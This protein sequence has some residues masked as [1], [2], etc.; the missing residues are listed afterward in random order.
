M[1]GYGVSDI[2]T[3]QPVTEHTIFFTGSTSKAFT[4]AAISL[5][6]DDSINFPDIHW[7][8]LVHTILPTDFV[9]ND[10]WAT[11]QMTIVDILSHRSG[12]PRHDWVWLANIT[13]QEAVQSMQHLPFT[14]SPRTEWQYC[15]LMYSAASHLIETVTNQSLQSFLRDNIWLP[16]DMTETYLSLS[17]SQDAHRDISQG[18]FVNLDGEI[19]PTDRVST[20]IL[21]GAGNIL[22]SV[23]DYSKWVSTMLNRGPPF[24]SAGYE[25]LF[26]AHSIESLNPTEPFQSPTL[27]GLGWTIQ[28]YKG[29]M[30]LSHGGAQVGYGASVILLPQRNFGLV[31][32][33]NNMNGIS[34]AAD[35]LAYHLID[36]ELEVPLERRYDWVARYANRCFIA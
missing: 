19:T 22:S 21:H 18:Y 5:L 20:D 2:L 28:T 26:G 24:S 36:E 10:S 12:L 29:E 13:L 31:L 9:L 34:A 6:V 8:T 25:M 30:I 11:S 27:Y 32:L 35:V 4:S 1:K 33:G 16:L 15:N 3:S 7:D 14:A 23:S 17:D